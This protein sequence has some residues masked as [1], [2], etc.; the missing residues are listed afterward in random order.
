MGQGFKLRG[1][2]DVVPGHI[3]LDLV[4][5]HTVGVEFHLNRSRGVGHGLNDV[6]NILFVEMVNDFLAQFIVTYCAD[7][8]TFEAKLRNMISEIGRRTAKLLAFGEYIPQ[9]FAH[10]DDYLIF[11]SD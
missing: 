11:H 10:S 5:G 6:A 8:I 7:D 9:G 1:E 2:G 4:L 3:L